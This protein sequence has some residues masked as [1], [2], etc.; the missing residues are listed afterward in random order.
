L[1]Y[2]ARHVAIS[3]DEIIKGAILL[4]GVP[5]AKDVEILDYYKAEVAFAPNAKDNLD[6]AVL[7]IA[8]RGAPFKSLPLATAK[9]E[10]GA[11][12]AVLGFPVVPG[13]QPGLSF[14][15][16]SV[17]NT[18]VRLLDRSHYQTDA[19]VNSGNSGGPFLNAKGEVAGIV[20]MK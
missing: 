14:N 2:T 20:T 9:L 6:F 12:V 18:K 8:G 4:V 17:S 19:A 1:I 15:K 7:K 3:P 5:S 10:L 13:E 16:G 11:D